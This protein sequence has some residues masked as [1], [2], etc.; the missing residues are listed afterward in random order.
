MINV[1][2]RC[3]VPYSQAVVLSQYFDLEHMEHVHPCTFG[4]ARMV[5][6]KPGADRAT[7][8]CIVPAQSRTLAHFSCLWAALRAPGNEFSDFTAALISQ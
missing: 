5:S 2:Y 6:T 1:Q 4:C 8:S 3:E 7:Y